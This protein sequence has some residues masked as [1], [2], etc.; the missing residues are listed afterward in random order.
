LALPNGWVST[1]ASADFS[2]AGRGEMTTLPFTVKPPSAETRLVVNAVATVDG[3]QATSGMETIRYPHFAPQSLF[4]PAAS[5][6]LRTNVRS[7]AKRVGYIMGAG[8]E[9]P[10]AI[11]QLGADVTMLGEAQLST[12]NFSN[13]DAVV[14]GIRAYNGRADL[15]ANHGRLMEYVKQGGTVVVQYNVAERGGFG[16]PPRGDLAHVGPYPLTVGSDRVTVEEAPIELPNPASPLLHKPNEITG[17]DFAGWIQER[18]LYFASEWEPQYGSRFAS[19]DPGEKLS[20]GATLVAYYGKGTY[21]YTPMSWWRQLP[22]GVPGAY[23]IF[24]NF[25]SA[26]SPGAK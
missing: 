2:L 22:A 11:K 3:T 21:I 26:R 20:K 25:L 4:P 15:R 24:A 17:A 19:H 14:V 18:G 16:G 10:A 9:V 13:F 12:A 23:R 8:D 6:L 1:P 7:T 5:V